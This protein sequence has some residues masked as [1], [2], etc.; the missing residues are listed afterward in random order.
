VCLTFDDG[1]HIEGTPAVLAVLADAGVTATFFLVGE[2]VVRAPALAAEIAA[3]GHAIG[4]HGYRHRNQL[5]L[6]PAALDD[7]Y[8]R[9]A[10]AV[11][12]ATGVEPHAYR[13]AYGIFSAAGLALVHRRGWDPML[14]SRW[15]RD[16]RRHTSA[17]KIAAKATEHLRAGDVVLLHD[18]DAYSAPGSWR[19]TAQALPLVLEA[20]S[21][22]GLRGIGI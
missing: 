20:M 1:P 11:A 2:Q 21:R 3:A 16:W 22:R 6:S 19:R 5:R 13:P 7:D 18:S 14:W 17:E 4:L 12:A 8:S 9:G 10:E 15:G